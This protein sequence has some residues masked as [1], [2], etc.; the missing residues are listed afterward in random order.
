M[1]P[2][3][4][5]AQ[6]VNRKVGDRDREYVL[7]MNAEQP[8]NDQQPLRSFGWTS[9]RATRVYKIQHAP[10]EELLEYLQLTP[11]PDAPPADWNAAS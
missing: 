6:W 9:S 2:Q 8:A 10:F 7:V 11:M 5:W 4:V 3:H 1:W